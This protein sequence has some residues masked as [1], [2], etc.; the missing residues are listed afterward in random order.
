MR[1]VRV[2]HQVVDLNEDEIIIK[3]ASV[4]GPIERIKSIF[5]LAGFNNDNELFNYG[6]E[7]IQQ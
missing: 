7:R 6:L 4:Y 5:G 2:E 1:R 3:R